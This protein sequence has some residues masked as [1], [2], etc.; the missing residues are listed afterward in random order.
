LWSLKKDSVRERR[1]CKSEYACRSSSGIAW[2]FG[3]VGFLFGVWRGGNFLWVF[4]V[5]S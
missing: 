3:V 2:N 1:N 4:G 5:G